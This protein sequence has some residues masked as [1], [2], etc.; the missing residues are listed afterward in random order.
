MGWKPNGYFRPFCGILSCKATISDGKGVD[1]LKNQ[2]GWAQGEC[3]QRA[4]P[5]RM[6]AVAAGRRA[7]GGRAYTDQVDQVR[8]NSGSTGRER[9]F[10]GKK[11]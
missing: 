6:T 5:V 11:V 7:A 3:L 2:L 9:E 10:E 8:A 1:G 4:P